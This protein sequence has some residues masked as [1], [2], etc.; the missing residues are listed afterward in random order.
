MTQMVNE[1]YFSKGELKIANEFKKS[2]D[3]FLG[4]KNQ[5]TL[6]S[7]S[8]NESFDKFKG[9]LNKRFIPL[10]DKICFDRQVIGCWPYLCCEDYANYKKIFNVGFDSGKSLQDVYN[11]FADK[12]FKI[13]GKKWDI[14][15]K[16]ELL[17]LTKLENIPFKT[18]TKFPD[19]FTHNYT[20]YKYK[21]NEYDKYLIQGFYVYYNDL[22][23]RDGGN[24][25][26][27]FRLTTNKDISDKEIFM[28]FLKHKLKPIGYNDQFYKLLLEF[29]LD[30]LTGDWSRLDSFID[31]NFLIN[32]LKKSDKIRANL[33]E[34]DQKIFL[35]VN[36][37]SWEIFKKQTKLNEDDIKVQLPNSLVARDPKSDIIDG[38]I[39]IDFGTKSTVVVASKENDHILPLR[40]GVGD[41]SKKI[42]P[43]HYENPTVMEFIDFNT[44]LNDYNRFDFRPYTKYKDLTISHTAYENLKKSN[45]NDFNAYLTELKQ[46][47]GDKN[48]K[49]KIKDKSKGK[50][51]ELKPFLQLEDD[52][53]NPIELYAYYLGLYI[54]NQYRGIYLNYI[55]SFPVTYE[56]KIRQKLL[57]SFEAGLRRSLPDIGDKI[58][59][60]S[61]VAGVSEPASYA[62]IALQEY[63]LGE[64]E[65]NFYAI[66]D[67]G[68][69]TTDFDFGVFRWSD[70]NS[71][72]EKRFDYV[73]EHFGAGGDKYLGGENILELLAFEIFKE[74]SDILLE[75]NISFELPAESTEFLGSEILLSTS[76]EARL[77]MVNLISK[78]RPFWEREEFDKPVFE[79]EFKV[80]LYDNNGVLQSGL[81]MKIDENRLVE[82]LRNRIAKGVDSFFEG[83]REVFANYKDEID[84]NTDIIHIFLA[85]NSS[86]S[87][88][89][90]ELFEQKIDKLQKDFQSKN[91][92][93]KFELYPPLDNQNNSEKPNGKTGVAF[94]LIETRP[95]GKIL[96]IDRN[97]KQSDIKF[98]YYLGV[99]RRKRFR[100]VI[101]KEQ[102]YNQW[103]EFID[104]SYSDFEVYYTSLASATTNLMD[105]TDDTIKRRR[106]KI[107]KTDENKN[108]YI[109]LVEPNVF[110][111]GIG[112]DKNSIKACAK[113]EIG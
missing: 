23:I 31:T 7:K 98:K 66:F 68:G 46:W 72:K 74:N 63:G 3:A 103:V 84:L 18:R 89:A 37:G 15:T 52:D 45:S 5:N 100:V 109:R 97:I 44:F 105:I 20:L 92:K 10:E 80:D 87:P 47:A 12:S 8:L 93:G 86:K 110:E 42:E 13:D 36:Q 33:R 16:D 27:I 9:L 43:Y 108:I 49:L 73:I 91:Y 94:G 24:P 14:P 11:Y 41:W 60:L 107:K 21:Q 64:N 99:N 57:L 34:Y 28:L 113:V 56:M 54:N 77:N 81:E 70:E 53:I 106:L 38:I 22:G 95:G 51:F 67:F 62:S 101:S 55:L 59:D 4:N 112:E 58:G 19:V 90:K 76:R 82:I 29:D 6:F 85:G 78:I 75:R 102:E 71:K 50:T 25:Y 88:I 96:V 26:P 1:I 65:K 69:G 30:K 17:T 32:N 83:L 79:N 2:I 40:V 35:D 48:R 111:Y 39:G 61:V 104:A